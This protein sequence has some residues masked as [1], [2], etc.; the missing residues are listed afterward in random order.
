MAQARSKHPRAIQPRLEDAHPPLS[1]PLAAE[2]CV[3]SP[4]RQSVHPLLVM[5]RWNPQIKEPKYIM[6][7]LNKLH[8]RSTHDVVRAAGEVIN[9]GTA[10]TSWNNS[11]CPHHTPH[12]L[13]TSS[14]L[15]HVQ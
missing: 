4:R 2:K 5:D 15:L 12:R 11:Q 9:H 7:L 6:R 1:K 3:L 10:T 14:N 13:L 8:H